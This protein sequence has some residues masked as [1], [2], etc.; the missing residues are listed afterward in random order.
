MKITL[1]GSKTEVKLKLK[2]P[3]IG[4]DKKPTKNTDNIISFARQYPQFSKLQ[5]IEKCPNMTFGDMLPII[6][7]EIES[8]DPRERLKLFRW[9]TK[10]EDKMITDK[11]ELVLDLNQVT[12]LYD[13]INKSTRTAINI[14]IPI[15]L[16]FERLKEELSK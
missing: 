13:F 4:Y 6:L 2:N 8:T 5:L 15:I 1:D 9:A 14:H 11:A 12:E 10:I 7:L 16:E 3:I